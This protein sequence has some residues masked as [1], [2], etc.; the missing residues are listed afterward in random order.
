[1]RL[2]YAASA[3]SIGAGKVL[4]EARRY[5]IEATLAF[6]RRARRANAARYSVDRL[7]PL[8]ETGF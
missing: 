2:A 3:S 7:V 5:R 1:M 6:V 4:A 8:L